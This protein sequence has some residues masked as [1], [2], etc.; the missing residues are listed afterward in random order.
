MGYVRVYAG[1]HR[2]FSGARD[3]PLGS[4]YMRSYP[5]FIYTD[6]ERNP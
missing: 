5:V 2:E 1:A 3:K 4:F 6:V